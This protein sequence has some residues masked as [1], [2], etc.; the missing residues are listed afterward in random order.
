MWG[1]FQRGLIILGI[2][3][4]TGIFFQFAVE[5]EPSG[6][7]EMIIK[8]SPPPFLRDSSAWADSV[9]RQLDLNERIGQLMMVAVYPEQ[10]EAEIKRVEALIKKYKVGGLL[11]F[12]GTPEQTRDLTQYFQSISDNPLLVA[13]DGEWGPSMRISNTIKYPRQMM[14]GA[15][16]NDDLIYEMGR[17]IGQQLNLLGIHMNF[18]PVVDVNNNPANP[19]IGSRSFGEQRENVARKGIMYMKG[20]QSQHIIAVAKHF[21]GHGDTDTDSHHDLPLINQ[22]EKRI[23]SLELYPFKALIQNGVGGIMMAHLH[24]PALDATANLPSSLSPCIADSLLQKKM[25][26]K[27]L[28]ITDAM[29][30][31]GAAKN[32]TPVDANI[33]ALR[34]GNDILLMP[35]ELEKTIQ[36]IAVKALEDSAFSVGIDQK[37]RKILESKSWAVLPRLKDKIIKGSEL[38]DSL[39]SPYYELGYRKL[40]EA[41]VTVASN[42]NRLVPI[43]DLE[44]FSFAAV[45]VGNAPSD[46]FQEYLSLYTDVDAYKVSEKTSQEDLESL[47]RKLADYDLVFLSLHTDDF[48]AYKQYGFS[49][50][51]LSV[52]DEIL[53]TKNCILTAFTSPYLLSKLKKLN[54]AK[55][56]VVAYENDSLVQSVAAQVLFGAIPATGRLPVAISPEFPSGR[57]AYVKKLDRLKYTLP[58]EAG[59]DKKKLDLIDSLVYDGISQ[60]AMPGCQVLIAR[61]GKV[62][63]NRSYGHHTYDGKRAVQNTDLYDLASLTKVV[64]TLPCLMYLEK[65]HKI[66]LEKTLGDYLPGLDSCNKAGL[67]LKD[68]LL[69]Q[70][71]LKAYIPFYEDFLEPLYP[72]QEYS[73]SKYSSQYPIH[74]GKHKYVNKHLKYSEESFSREQDSICTEKIADGL[75]MNPAL[76]DSLYQKIYD[77]ELTDKGKYLYSDIGFILFADLIKEITGSSMDEFVRTKFY[78][79]LGATRMEFNPLKTYRPDDITPTEN[80]LVFRKQ[81]IQGHV[82]DPGA[83]MLGGVSGHAGLFSNANDLAKYSQ[84]LL[85]EGSYGGHRYLD[86]R[87]INKYASCPEGNEGNRRGLGFDKP[88]SDTT[89]VSPACRLASASSFGHTGF[90]GTMMWIDPESELVYIFLSN[91]VFPDVVTNKLAAMDIR[92]NIQK[93]IYESMIKDSKNL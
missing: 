85:N 73:R 86:S 37:C 55:A 8:P 26:F 62:I 33:L 90:T 2:L 91:R 36:A 32:F 14:L 87:L 66:D 39:N 75:F 77:S 29:N 72:N 65:A 31:Q 25:K 21:P 51:L 11:F 70:A 80:D 41:S 3:L 15:I 1:N 30:M 71:G 6:G 93:V 84:M 82:H 83:A 81:V 4:L 10:G 88:E 69:H 44:R 20:M 40:I 58:L 22:P 59:I 23:D 47:Q 42:P 53:A 56:L 48:R 78:R 60:E 45:S 9:Y 68:I 13:I 12:R 52:A 74:V 57:G 18:A 27:G 89:K 5:P 64:A 43:T 49:D 17:D 7:N 50:R 79:G 28:V 35:A 92:T 38:I 76:R 63:F 61:E 19:V 46:A 16:E 54:S 34:A 24:V 67:K